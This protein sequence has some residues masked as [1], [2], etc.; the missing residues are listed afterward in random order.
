MHSQDHLLVHGLPCRKAHGK[1]TDLR[2]IDH[3]GS[4]P[5]VLTILLIGCD[6]LQRAQPHVMTLHLQ[7][8]RTRGR[9]FQHRGVARHEW[10]H[11][12]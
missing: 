6:E 5:V 1:A 8:R 9:T 3:L 12:C 10:P 4:L 11:R 7:R 2:L